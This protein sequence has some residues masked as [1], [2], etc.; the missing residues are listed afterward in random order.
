MALPAVSCRI[1][2]VKKVNAPVHCLQNICR[3]TD[4]HQIR[5]FFKRQIRN[6]GIQNPV[7]LLMRFSYRKSSDGISRKIK[8]CDF[9]RMCNPDILQNSALI[10][11]EQQLMRIDRIRKT[12]QPL[13]VGLTSAKP[14]R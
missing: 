12:V 4:S 5:W 3:G 14:Q 8:L 6:N 9:L 11:S 7:H 13:N 2:A 1:N 10:D